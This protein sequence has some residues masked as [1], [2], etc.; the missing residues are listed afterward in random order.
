VEY[1][2]LKLFCAY[3]GKELKTFIL[4]CILFVFILQDH[5]KMSTWDYTAKGVKEKT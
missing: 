2:T 4:I 1:L 3:Y 5:G